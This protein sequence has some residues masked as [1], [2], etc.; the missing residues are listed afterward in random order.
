MADSQDKLTPADE[1]K[2][3]ELTK[4]INQEEP[5]NSGDKEAKPTQ[6]SSA[7]SS[8]PKLS[9]TDSTTTSKKVS[10][11][12]ASSEQPNPTRSSNGPLWLFTIINTLLLAAIV[13]AGYW[14]W[15]QWQGFTDSQQQKMT[16]QQASIQTQQRQIGQT[17]AASQT[18]EQGLAQQ[19]QALQTSIQSL[20]EQVQVTSEQ[21]RTNQQNLADVSGR[22]PSDWLLAEADYLVR[23][24]GRKLWL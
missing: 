21:V 7:K 18:V 15:T 12:G 11:N 23:M 13:V 4:Q 10:S 9:Q 5:V 6:T 3:A 2:L 1:K 16:E 17:L 24:A 8:S 20:I 14:G 22:R 19:N